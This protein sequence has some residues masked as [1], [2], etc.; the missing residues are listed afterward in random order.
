[1]QKRKG[2]REQQKL[3]AFASTP[4][5]QILGEGLG[6]KAERNNL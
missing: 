3:R 5:S 1:M 4:L 2:K 6:V